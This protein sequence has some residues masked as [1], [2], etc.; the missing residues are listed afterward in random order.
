MANG[1][2]PDPDIERD[3]YERASPLNMD[4]MNSE[5]SDIFELLRSMNQNGPGQNPFQNATPQQPPIPE[6]LL[7]KVIRSKIII[8]FIA[9]IVYFICATNNETFILGNIFTLLIG[10]ELIEIYLS[11]TIA[12]PPAPSGGM[13]NILFMFGG[14]SPIKTKMILKFLQLSN[15]VLRDVAIFMFSFV[16][17]HLFW[18][19]F[20]KNES[21]NEILDK[22]FSNYLKVEL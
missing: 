21:L 16:L 9:L 10:W 2:Y 5:N 13:L 6:T 14:I 8:V 3:V 4:V 20:V 22:D 11:S 19:F 17:L 12:P 15:K 7:S 1:F 18:S